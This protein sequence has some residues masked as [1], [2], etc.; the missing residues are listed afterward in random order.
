MINGISFKNFNI[1]PAP[2]F[3]ASENVTC[4]I[5]PI[6]CSLQGTEAIANYNMALINKKNN[7]FDIPQVEKIN[8]SNDINTI[9]GEKIYNSNGELIQIIDEN[10][11]LIKKF[12]PTNNGYKYEIINKKSNEKI[13]SQ[14]LNKEDNKKHILAVKY[15]NGYEYGTWYDNEIPERKFKLQNF[16]NG[17][18]K[19]IEYDFKTKEYNYMDYDAEKIQSNDIIYDENK[20]IINYDVRTLN[21]GTEHKTHYNIHNG[22]VYSKEDSFIQNC[23]DIALKYPLHDKDLTPLPKPNYETNINNIDGIKTYYS[24]GDLETITTPSGIKYSIPLDKNEQLKLKDGNK[25]IFMDKDGYIRIEEQ[26]GN[27]KKT[28]AYKNEECLGVS[29]AQ[30][31]L[32]K[33]LY[34]NQGKP[35]LY[36]ELNNG[37]CTSQIIFDQNRN[38]IK[39]TT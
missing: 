22:Q 1:T 21:N 26:I 19:A 16:K 39:K 24:N 13:F 27:S 30:E 23:S 32:K 12:I 34:F 10:D 15:E 5:Q 33:S 14:T 36:Q 7:I 4:P 28:T 11:S 35:T 8:F 17:S 20:K 2:S 6:E 3:K 18:N 31:G 9:K 29:Y 25:T 38:A 37:E